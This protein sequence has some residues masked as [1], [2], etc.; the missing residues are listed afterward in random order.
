MK[1]T[2]AAA[3][4]KNSRELT[5]RE[6]TTLIVCIIICQITCGTLYLNVVSFFP[7][8]VNQHYKDYISTFMTSCCL[9]AFQFAAVISTKVHQV[10]ISKM[11]RKNAVI[12]G[13]T[14]LLISTTCLGM[15]EYVPY[16]QW[17]LFYGLSIVIRFAQGYASSLIS[18]T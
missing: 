12:V 6:K 15:L 7:L 1:N 9:S 2:Y 13:F 11:G 18:T 4:K 3:T 17:K 14:I 5:P 8:F 16:D 10:T